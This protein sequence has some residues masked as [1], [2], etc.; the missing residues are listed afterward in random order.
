MK[1]LI[2]TLLLLGCSLKNANI[3]L[4]TPDS[5]SSTITTGY[6]PVVEIITPDGTHLCTG[7]FVSS[8][9]ILTAAHCA[10]DSGRYSIITPFNTFYSSNVIHFGPGTVSDTNDIALIIFN[11]SVSNQFYNIGTQTAIGD[12]LQLVGFGCDNID[13]KT[14]A[15]LKRTGSNMVDAL[16]YFIQFV[17]P[18]TSTDSGILGPDNVAGSCFGDSGGPAL[19]SNLQVVGVTHAGGNEG[20][21]ILSQYVDLINQQTNRNWIAAQNVAYNLNIIME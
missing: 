3:T 1:Y 21:Y 14:G 4:P 19:N 9:V 11:S 17:T 12:I 10:L 18:I 8:V 15:G 5:S 13:S 16:G 7:T 2:F 20:S 6:N